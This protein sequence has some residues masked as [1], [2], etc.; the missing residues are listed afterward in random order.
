MIKTDLVKKLQLTSNSFFLQAEIIIKSYK[1]KLKIDISRK[2]KLFR[3][4]K[5][6]SSSL[7]FNQLLGVLKDFLKIFFM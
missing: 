2:F 3:K 6:K 7:S 1:K 4:K 5:Y